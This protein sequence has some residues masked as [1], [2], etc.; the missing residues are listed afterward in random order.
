MVRLC[1]ETMEKSGE[2]PALQSSPK[3]VGAQ[4]E[5][6]GLV[7]HA[8]RTQGVLNVNRMKI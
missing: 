8:H 1:L 6:L 4:S 2:R 7:P 5:R 3:K